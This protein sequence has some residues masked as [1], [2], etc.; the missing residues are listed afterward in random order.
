MHQRPLPQ[1]GSRPLHRPRQPEGPRRAQ[2]VRARQQH[3][4][5]PQARGRRMTAFPA[6]KAPLRALHHDRSP[7]AAPA[8]L[9]KRSL[10]PP[11]A[12]SFTG[13]EG[14]PGAKFLRH[15]PSIDANMV[16]LLAALPKPLRV[17]PVVTGVRIENAHYLAWLA[18][19]AGVE[20]R[21]VSK[22]L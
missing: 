5:R 2:L 8:A 11:N 21:A 1:L 18:K 22:E 15:A 20:D 16:S 13:S 12:D 17:K 19:A 7:T 3:P 10:T 9:D 4:R 14:D 6:S